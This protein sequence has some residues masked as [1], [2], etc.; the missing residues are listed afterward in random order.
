VATYKVLQDIEAE[1][2]L[3]GPLSLRQSIYAVIVIVLGFVGFKLATVKWFF[4]IPFLPPIIFFALL[5]APLGRD[6]PSEVWLLA[7]IRFMVKTRR[8]IWNQSGVKELV[9]ITV[10]KTIERIYTKGFS[11]EEVKSR[12]Q[13]LSAML[14]TR[15]WA[16]KNVDV[17]TFRQPLIA[18]NSSSDRL[19]DITTVPKE[20]PA[21]SIDPKSDILDD[22][23][24]P[25]A[26]HVD[27]TLAQSAQAHRQELLQKVR[28]IAEEQRQATQVRVDKGAASI[29][30][31]Q[32]ELDKLLREA[33][34]K[35]KTNTVTMSQLQP[36][37]T[38]TSQPLNQAPETPSQTAVTPVK[39][40]AILK[41]VKSNDLNV[42]TIAREANRKSG[43]LP[44]DDEVVIS[45]H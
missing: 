17:S 13:A 19:V 12:L 37:Q 31:G 44:P 41:L 18:A 29:K 34:A 15:G 6:Q 14:D 27:Q 40:P 28:S 11:D 2:K 16:V 3:L 33:Q 10:P 24:N 38:S 20:D 36:T 32:D 42:S 5:A 21:A 7:K 30:Q 26:Q 1:D 45:L 39:D 8:R 23:N 4:A 35:E 22:T 9:T 25:V 43:E